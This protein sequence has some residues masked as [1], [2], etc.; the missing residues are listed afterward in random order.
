MQ[1]SQTIVKFENL[2]YPFCKAARK[3]REERTPIIKNILK[4]KKQAK[5]RHIL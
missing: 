3:S 5:G 2:T 4:A 1:L